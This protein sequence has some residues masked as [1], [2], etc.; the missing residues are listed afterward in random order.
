MEVTR[1]KL[2]L[3]SGLL[4][5]I[6]SPALAQKESIFNYV[7]SPQVEL[8]TNPYEDP[9]LISNPWWMRVMQ[10]D[11]FKTDPTGHS[12]PVGDQCDPS[13]LQ[14]TKAQGPLEIQ[15]YFTKCEPS[16]RT[17]KT[18]IFS[19]IYYSVFLQLHTDNHPIAKHV[20]LHL[21]GGVNVKG[22]LGLKPGGVKR[23]LVILR[24]GI[25]SNAMSFYPERS[26]FMQLF[27]QSSYNILVLE[28][29]SGS[30]YPIHN[31]RFGL[32]GFEEGLQN[33]YIA[34]MLQDPK[35]PISNLID[36]VHLVGVSLGGHGA[37]F[38]ALLNEL[39]PPAISSF[40]GICPL[41]NF[42]QTY[43]FHRANQWK[44]KILN[45][46]ANLRNGT[47]RRLFPDLSSNY[48][49]QDLLDHMK[50]ADAPYDANAWQVRLPPGFENKMFTERLNFWPEWKNV[51]SPFLVFATE[52][53]P[54]VPY[55]LNSGMLADHDIDVGDS[56]LAVVN[57][58][59]GYHC[60]IP[61]AY[62]WRAFTDILQKYIKVNAKEWVPQSTGMQSGLELGGRKFEVQ[63]GEFDAKLTILDGLAN[64]FA[65]IPA[66]MISNGL[67]VKGPFSHESS[68]M[69]RRW[70]EQ[71]LHSKP[72]DQDKNKDM[73]V[74][75]EY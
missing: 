18:D 11:T 40:I 45:F 71:T 15:K 63:V 54:I 43:E 27:E 16:L 32:G 10:D 58:P 55:D 59:K 12:E 5:L 7:V 19:N 51:H 38:A 3:V 33:Y 2:Y 70:L 23:P 68:S 61:A 28:S 9:L 29:T 39:N 49:I 57:L 73:D 4:F 60:S 42:N 6:F 31:D 30:E 22:L 46:W 8:L 52:S 64:R 47:L 72:K 41:V 53:D 37:F 62:N 36:S 50:V 69:I 75:W 67:G 13:H 74:F 17:G 34:R 44:M 26:L 65:I 66:T 25:F 14:L 56:N 35:E 48:F 24:L 20:M 1:I 21:P